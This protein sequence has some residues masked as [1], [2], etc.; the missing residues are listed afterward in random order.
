MTNSL[1]TKIKKLCHDGK[2]DMAEQ[3][4]LLRKLDCHDREIRANE[5]AKVI[6]LLNEGG[7]LFNADEWGEYLGGSDEFFLKGIL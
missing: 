3:E 2:I 1:R 7:Y 6:K 4:I 5:R